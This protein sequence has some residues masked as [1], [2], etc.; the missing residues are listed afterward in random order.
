MDYIIDYTKSN[1]YWSGQ[2]A[3]VNGMLGGFEILTK[4]DVIG[5][6]EFI[7][8]FITR[9]SAAAPFTIETNLACG[10]Q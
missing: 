7:K 2:P 3:T 10:K 1:N 4:P 8:P 6:T 5:S 9:D